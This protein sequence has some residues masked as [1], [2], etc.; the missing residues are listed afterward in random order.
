[1]GFTDK[2]ERN[3]ATGSGG[4]QDS[5]QPGPMPNVS[6]LIGQAEAVAND[7]WNQGRDLLQSP[8]GSG[9]TG[10]QVGAAGNMWEW[11]SGLAISELSGEA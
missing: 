5:A 6:P 8:Q 2:Q 1:M 10:H 7:R 4:E 3:G 9:T 11:D